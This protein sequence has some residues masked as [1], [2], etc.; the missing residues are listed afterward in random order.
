MRLRA[1]GLALA[2]SATMPAATAAADGLPVIGIDGGRAGVRAADGD[3]RF[4]T[5]KAGVNTRI[6]ELGGPER[7]TV[8][9][10]RVVRGRYT[11]P[12][13]ALDGTPSGVSAD[14]RTL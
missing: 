11:I 1:V 7:A 5:R 14:G 9:R 2:V 10:S 4:V 8:I 13:V 3:T 6:S 12:V